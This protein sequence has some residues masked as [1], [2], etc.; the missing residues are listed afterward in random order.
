MSEKHFP[1]HFINCK[2]YYFI[3][4]SIG[5]S[6]K[7][8]SENNQGMQDLRGLEWERKKKQLYK[9]NTTIFILD[10]FAEL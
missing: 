6:N 9:G 5:S 2:E 10:A 1:N 8:I 3:M 7:T 4:A